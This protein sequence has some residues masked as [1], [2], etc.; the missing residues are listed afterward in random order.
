[1][2]MWGC[3]QVN[4]AAKLAYF[5]VKTTNMYPGL[6]QSPLVYGLFPGG[7]KDPTT[8]V[9]PHKRKL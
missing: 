7:V 8:E 9:H 6:D 1:M 2:Q 3:E 5:L 4:K